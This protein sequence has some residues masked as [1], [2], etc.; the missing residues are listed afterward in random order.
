MDDDLSDLESDASGASFDE[1]IV[2]GVGGA[3]GIAIGTV[4]CY[5][6]RAP[7]VKQTHVDPGAVETELELLQ[8]ALDRAERELGKIQS[9]AQGRVGMKGEA[10]LEAQELMLQDEEVLDA[11]RSRIREHHESAAYALSTVLGDYRRRLEESDDEYFRE[12]A[13]DLVKLERHLIE[14]LQRSRTAETIEPNSIVVAERLSAADLIRFSQHGML[15]FVMSKG[16]ETSHVAIV[17][18]ALHLPAVV[19]AEGVLDAVS[20]HDR[21]I[22]DGR[23]GRLVLHPSAETLERYRKRRARTESIR[24]AYVDQEEGTASRTA[25]DQRITLQANVDFGETLQDLDRYGA[26]GIGLMRTEVVFLSGGGTEP[27][28]DQQADVYETAVQKTGPE[29]ATIRLLDLGGDKLMPFAQKEDNPFLGWRGI[30]VLL[31]RKETL[32]RP[33]IRALL[34]ANAHGTIRVLLPMVSHLDEVRAVR[35]VVDEEADRLASQN[36]EHD[37]ELSLG[38]MVEVPAVALQVRQFAAA[39]DFLSIGT[40][41]LTQYVLAV[42]RGNDRVA[43]RYDSLHPAVLDLIRRTVDGAKAAD[44][45][46]A[47]CG[48]MASDVYA[49]PVLLGLGLDTLSVSPPSLPVVRHVISSVSLSD[50]QPLASEVLSAADAGAVRRLVREWMNKYIDSDFLD[51]KSA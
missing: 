40:N 39:C 12:R 27:D 16:G 5:R 21:I 13:G 1:R 33:Q 18:R 28:E 22:L 3:P 2:E 30:R 6:E 42:D 24:E 15:G 7:E 38:V 31:D 37:A 41:D 36:V 44:I 47:L 43:N 8:D 19:G 48:E 50:A 46:V 14:S 23:R 20:D 4:H 49:V 32:L 10:L 29:G 35:R 51:P 26:E 9:F 25:D 11:V 17:A 34:R 45:P